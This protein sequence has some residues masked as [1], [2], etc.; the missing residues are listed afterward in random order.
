MVVLAGAAL[1]VELSLEVSLLNDLQLV[2]TSK[3]IIPIIQTD[4][5]IIPA[6]YPHAFFMP[7]D[8]EKI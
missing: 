4:R 7:N 6:I 1:A 8:V 3:I 2:N 5:F